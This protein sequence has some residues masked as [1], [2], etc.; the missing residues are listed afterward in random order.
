MYVR[1][2][3]GINMELK[4][5]EFVDDIA[6]PNRNKYDAQISNKVITGIQEL[7][8][9]KFS[10]KKCKV[11][12][13]NSFSNRDTLFIE[14]RA[15]DIENSTSYLG[16]MFNNDKGDNTALCKHRTDKAVRTIIELFSICK[17]VYFGKFKISNLLTLYQSV[18]I[19]RL[20]YNCEAWSNLKAKDY[21]VLQKLQL[22][23]L[24]RVKMLRYSWNLV[25]GQCKTLLSNVNCFT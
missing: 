12:K 20:I 11:L 16:D 18:F 17:E 14:D 24:K 7:K 13:I 5:L 22:N 23:F 3:N 2:G 9:L 1:K 19:P 15:L 21:Q 25:F 4:P 8:K 10:S 6:N